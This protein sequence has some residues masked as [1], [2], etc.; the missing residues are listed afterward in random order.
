M[1]RGRELV[2]AELERLGWTAGEGPVH[3]AL[4]GA[5]SLRL[6]RR[7]LRELKAQRRARLRGEARARRVH[8]VAHARDV[9]WCLDATHVG[10]DGRGRAVQ[11][12]VLR[13]VACTRTLSISV[14]PV[15]SSAEVIAQL[16]ATA[17]ERGVLPLVLAT[18]NGA[19]YRSAELEEWLAERQVVHLRNLPRTPQ[20]NACA[21]HGM[22]ELKPE[23]G[24]GVPA[25]GRSRVKG[26]LVDAG[27]ACARLAAAAVRLDSRR[28]RRSRGWRTAFQVEADLPPW[29]RLATRARVW[30]KVCC[31]LGRSRLASEGRRARRLA[32]REAI[33][34]TL[35]QCGLLTRN[36]GGCQS[37]QRETASVS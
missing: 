37:P 25:A 22:G 20:H 7:V 4:G 26:G 32:E 24:L 1:A 16:Q 21:E 31:A 29:S 30:K 3:R 18:D 13:D 6:V 5:V 36:R 17:R 15:A 11:A 33:L 14:G 28:P 19:A 8:V 10:R 9:I 27:D 12:E 2:V 34:G 35:E 23:A